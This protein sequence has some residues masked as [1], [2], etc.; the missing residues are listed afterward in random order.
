MTGSRIH[1]SIPVC[2]QKK[3]KQ[4]V[5]DPGPITP[6]G[7]VILTAPQM[8]APRSGVKGLPAMALPAMAPPSRGLGLIPPLP[9]E[10]GGARPRA[11]PEQAETTHP[12]KL[13]PQQGDVFSQQNGRVLS[14]L[15]SLPI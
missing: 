13:K 5:R 3:T 11:W 4:E 1:P 9:L 7:W 14:D 10:H 12:G 6:R 2:F 15:G 8:H